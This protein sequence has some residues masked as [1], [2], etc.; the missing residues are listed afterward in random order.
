MPLELTEC[1]SAVYR[2][3]VHFVSLNTENE[4]YQQIMD[5]ITYGVCIR[6]ISNANLFVIGSVR[7][8]TYKYSGYWHHRANDAYVRVA[9]LSTH[10]RSANLPIFIME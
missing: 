2:Y 7:C 6:R 3:G 10:T 1:E 8:V 9:V 5:N 4:F